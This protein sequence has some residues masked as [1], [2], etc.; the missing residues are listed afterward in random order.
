[1]ERDR[2]NE[3]TILVV[4]DDIIG[5]EPLKNILELACDN[6]I[7]ASNGLE[8]L[9]KL[10][11]IKPDMILSD[12]EMPVMNGMEFYSRVKE[13]KDLRHIPFIFF[14]VPDKKKASR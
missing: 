2:M 12:L 6:V 5:L 1:M 10:E 3:L 9:A 4:K 14:P 13:K 7:L 8:A 11:T